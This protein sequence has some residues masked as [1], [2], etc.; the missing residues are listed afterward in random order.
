MNPAALSRR[1]TVTQ[2]WNGDGDASMNSHNPRALAPEIPKSFPVPSV[3]GPP[4]LP[5]EPC[6]TI[7]ADAGFARVERCAHYYRNR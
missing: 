6:F 2:R 5:A 3:V 4:L 1:A 7:I